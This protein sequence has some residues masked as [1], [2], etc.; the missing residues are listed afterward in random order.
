MPHLS[1]ILLKPMHHVFYLFRVPGENVERF[2]EIVSAASGIYR[3][4]SVAGQALLL[5]AV[6]QEEFF[7]FRVTSSARWKT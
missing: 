6:I 5:I 2:L 4:Y 3:R 7:D 1:A